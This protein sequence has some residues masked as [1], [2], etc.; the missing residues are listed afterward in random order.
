MNN[1]G[2]KRNPLLLQMNSV[3]ALLFAQFLTHIFMMERKLLCETR[4]NLILNCNYLNP[5]F[6]NEK[7]KRK[8]YNAQTVQK[9]CI[10]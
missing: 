6:K 7:H 1:E 2:T 9:L 4:N 5:L 8:K 3:I 10:S